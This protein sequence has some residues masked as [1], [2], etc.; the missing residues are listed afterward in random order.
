VSVAADYPLMDAFWTLFIFFAWV[1]WIWVLVVILTDVF[2]RHDIGGWAKAGWT[3]F[4]IFLPL[5]GVLAYLIAEGKEMG[6]RNAAEQQA[7]RAETDSYIRSV[8]TQ[9]DPAEQIA[10]GKQLL[11]S[12]AITAAEFDALKQRALAG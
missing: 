8:A 11:D 10:K 9:G 12:G 5:L 7:V 3:V 6:E 4:V 2:R 1:L